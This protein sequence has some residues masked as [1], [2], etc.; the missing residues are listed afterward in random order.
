MPSLHKQLT[1]EH[2]DISTPRQTKKRRLNST[3]ESSPLHFDSSPIKYGGGVLPSIDLPE[4]EA[5]TV[6]DEEFTVGG[7]VNKR[8][9]FPRPIIKLGALHTSEKVMMRAFGGPGK[10][11]R[12]RINDICVDWRHS[13]NNFYTPPGDMHNF[14]S[15]ALPFCATPCNTNSLVAVGDE[16]GNIILIDSSQSKNVQFSDHHVTFRP[17]TNAVMD[18]SFSSDDYLFATAAGDQTSR[19]IDMRTQQTRFILRGHTSS[20]KQVRFQPGNDNILATSSRDGSVQLWDLRCRA[21]M[22][23]AK[24]ICGFESGDRVKMSC[25]N[26]RQ[27]LYA[28]TCISIQDAHSSTPTGSILSA[29]ALR[30]R[31][32]SEAVYSRPDHSTSAFSVSRRPDVSITAISFLSQPG[33]EHI[34]LSASEADA[35]IKVW[36]IRHK[37][38]TRR[39]GTVPISS[40][41]EPSSH[42]YQ[43]KFG[44][45][46]LCLNSDASRLYA[47]CRDNSV[48]TYNTSHLILGHAPELE[49]QSSISAS[50]RWRTTASSTKRGIAPLYALRHPSLSVSS[51]YV[52]ASVRKAQGSRDEVIAVGSRDGTAIVFPTDE[53]VFQ[54]STAAAGVNSRRKSEVSCE[55]LSRASPSTFL[56][57]DEK[58]PYDFEEQDLE[59]DDEGPIEPGTHTKVINNVGAALVRAHSKEVTAVCWT[60]DGDLVTLSDDYTARCWRED[61]ENA[62]RL[63]MNGESE[64]RR[65]KS[66]W[67]ELNRGDQNWDVDAN[68]GDDI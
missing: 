15:T 1:A 23:P 18:I 55:R 14:R 48:Y 19:V 58:T 38:S 39:N 2:T 65:W 63:R 21:T 20:V 52:K 47:L 3:I 51:F 61:A 13:T 67:A 45:T 16:A 46:S 62:R 41:L 68:D 4:I 10:L 56:H 54:F 44:L 42:L 33:R 66:G 37:F 32:D 49:A 17:H 7:L 27:V 11:K 53:N 59:S 60:H 30:S 40:T 24:D 29:N 50:S 31:R 57:K 34:L 5:A 6:S 9:R 26:E 12:G 64:G 36:D 25:M 28:N 35:S 43:R 8:G 22:G